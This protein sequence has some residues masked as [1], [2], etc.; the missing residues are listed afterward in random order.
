MELWSPGGR[1]ARAGG[2]IPG[3]R[4]R[5]KRP[6][7]LPHDRTAPLEVRFWA[8]VR[9]PGVGC[10]PQGSTPAGS[11]PPRGLPRAPRLQGARPSRNSPRPG[12]PRAPRSA[13]RPPPSGTPARE[14]GRNW[15]R[16]IPLRERRDVS[17]RRPLRGVPSRSPAGLTLRALESQLLLGRGY[18]APEE[19]MPHPWDAGASA[20]RCVPATPQVFGGGAGALRLRI[21]GSRSAT[22]PPD[23]VDPGGEDGAR[24][25]VPW[26]AARQRTF[27]VRRTRGLPSLCGPLSHAPARGSDLEQRNS[28]LLCNRQP[29]LALTWYVGETGLE[30]PILVPPPLGL[31]RCALPS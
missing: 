14:S 2:L 29:R 5:T 24:V 8:Q 26:L 18:R 7:L 27:S 23:F 9:V 6:R 17:A 19:R 11:A 31:Q 30:H 1:G 20:G 22:R 12:I 16:K 3:L 21:P 28:V 4:K 13:A 25:A 10:G 15:E